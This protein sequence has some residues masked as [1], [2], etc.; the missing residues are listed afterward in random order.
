MITQNN[1]V[2]LKHLVQEQAAAT[3][4][5]GQGNKELLESLLKQLHRMA[6]AEAEEY[7]QLSKA[8]RRNARRAQHVSESESESESA[9]PGKYAV[10]AAAKRQK[11]LE[12]KALE[13]GKEHKESPGQREGS[14]RKVKKEKIG[15]KRNKEKK[16]KKEKKEEKKRLALP[17]AEPPDAVREAPVSPNATPKRRKRG[18]SEAAGKSGRS[19]AT[20]SQRPGR[21]AEGEAARQAG[22][23]AGLARA[24]EDSD[25]DIRMAGFAA[26]PPSSAALVLVEPERTKAVKAPE[27]MIHFQNF[28]SRELTAHFRHSEDLQLFLT[29]LERESL[30]SPLE[31]LEAALAGWNPSKATCQQYWASMTY[32]GQLQ[33]GNFVKS[34]RNREACMDKNCSARV[35]VGCAWVATMQA[36]V[37]RR[38]EQEEEESRLRAS[39]SSPRRDLL[40]SFAAGAETEA[41]NEDEDC[42]E[43]EGEE[44]EGTKEQDEDVDL[45]DL[46]VWSHGVGQLGKESGKQG[47]V[48][49]R[50]LGSRVRCASQQTTPG[51]VQN[52]SP[53]LLLRLKS[54]PS[55]AETPRGAEPRF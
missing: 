34:V 19:E 24:P 26:R 1:L 13:E 50:R 20:G 25:E 28:F 47:R 55:G 32:G 36:D 10:Q 2:A 29:L 30:S 52:S 23:L 9:A 14:E 6:S 8:P 48:G 37:M 40:S 38:I 44:E 46:L 45:D 35:W 31:I 4:A 39:A 11:E 43:E 33:A 15:K 22:R 21:Q 49:A 42:L 12:E 53:A 16:Q 54:T 17:E 41:N 5:A 27:S 7:N 51:L 3:A 18:R